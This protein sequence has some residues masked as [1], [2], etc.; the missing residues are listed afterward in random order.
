MR[1]F[2]SFASKLWEMNYQPVPI[3]P[4]TKILRV[5]NSNEIF[6]KN[7]LSIN[8]LESYIES[9]GDWHIGVACG[10]PSGGLVCIDFDYEGFEDS[11]RTRNILEGII[12]SSP[13]RKKGK[14]GFS[15]FFRAEGFSRKTRHIKRNGKPFVDI[16]G[17]G[18]F[19]VLPPSNHSEGI[20]YHWLTPDT[21][22]TVQINEL[23]IL[24]PQNIQL[25]EELGE[26]KFN[27]EDEFIFQSSRHERV[28]GFIY[29]QSDWVE[30]IDDLIKQVIS[31]DEKINSLDPKG[32]YFSD[33]KYSNGKTPNEIAEKL[34]KR[35]C[36]WKT[37][38][39]KEI[40][41]TWAIGKT[42]KNYAQGKKQSTK[43][44][45]FCSF[46]EH[47]YP[48]SR[49][50]LITKIPY[51]NLNGKRVP[52]EK[53]IKDIVESQVSEVGLAVTYVNRH[54]NRWFSEKEKKLLIDFKKWDGID[55]IDKMVS[56]L[57]ILNI[58]HEFSSEIFKEWMGKMINRAFNSSV[59]NKFIILKGDQGIGKDTFI[60]HLVR[61]L[62]MYESEIVI[63]RDKKENYKT[64]T[65][66]ICA[67]IPEFDETHKLE[68]SVLKSI[69][70]SE[71]VNFRGSFEKY[72][73]HRTPHAS[74]I[75][76]ANF[77]NLLRDHSGN[78]RFVIFDIASINWDFLLSIKSEDILAQAY[79]LYKIKYKASKAALDIMASY[80]KEAT[81]P[82]P[83]D[84][85]LLEC[86][87]IIKDVRDGK[88]TQLRNAFTSGFTTGV[89]DKITWSMISNSIAN[90]ARTYGYQMGRIQR[91]LKKSGFSFNRGGTI[92]YTVPEKFE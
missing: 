76:S 38:R 3:E 49:V 33:S 70:T 65:S 50:D 83:E 22:L 17:N 72:S 86:A 40:G 53:D 11:E 9:H 87:Q 23:P 61:S 42:S 31:F 58:S 51:L 90:V 27:E 92:Y 14:K 71:K 10:D 81:P 41:I 54:I 48:D 62:D 69:I 67:Q 78:R 18:A 35:V 43:Y 52:C 1:I 63:D 46:F 89:T 21:L 77:D 56:H 88:V 15:V 25:I 39:K 19:T 75:S 84:S 26:M 59:Q 2:E 64:L 74:F 73:V 34:T 57:S 29:K 6:Y 45:D 82:N 79:H 80:I 32:P 37:R 36:D 24:T 47:N 66:L 16:I 20:D 60:K 30:S 55:W 4:G 13:V 5:K 28:F 44:E 12:P 8:T 7:L 68:L 91:I 85:F